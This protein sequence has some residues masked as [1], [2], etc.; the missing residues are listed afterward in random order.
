MGGLKR[1]RILD[2]VDAS[3][4]V[5]SKMPDVLTDPSDALAATPTVFHPEGQTRPGEK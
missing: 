2:V 5:A 1:G 3:G 4:V